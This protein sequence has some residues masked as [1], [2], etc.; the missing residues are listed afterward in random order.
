MEEKDNLKYRMSM[1]GQY[2]FKEHYCRIGISSI[3][4]FNGAESFLDHLNGN[5]YNSS[6][7]SWSSWYYMYCD[8]GDKVYHSQQNY[9]I[10]R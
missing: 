1:H 8:E 9:D 2:I 7:M 3:Y 6:K 10:W 4:L 5:R